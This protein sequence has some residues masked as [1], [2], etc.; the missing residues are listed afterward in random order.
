MVKQCSIVLVLACM[1][2]SCVHHRPKP[3]PIDTLP[4]KRITQNRALDSFNY[5]DVQ[6]RINV[7]LHTGYRQPRLILRGDT[8]DLAQLKVQ[9]RGQTLELILGKGFPHH[10]PIHADIHS[11]YLNGFKYDGYGSINGPNLHTSAI[12]L[13]ITNDGATRLSGVLGV[14][15]LRLAGKGFTSINGLSSNHL[16]LYLKGSPKVQ[17][18]GKANISNVVMGGNTWFSFYWLK[19]DTMVV[20]AKD[21]ARIQ[22]AG[23]VNRLDVELWGRAQFKGRYLR[24]Q[25]SFVK[26]HDRAVAEISAVNHQSNLATDASDIY[27]FNLANTRADFMAYNGSVLDMREWDRINYRDFDRY[28]KQ[29]P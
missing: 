16:Q 20:R 8:R 17:L 12:N 19:S 26:T 24:A 4:A 23:T 18:T 13:D 6:G 9:M 3:Q 7:T 2:M 25:R 15:S 14:Q 1:L 21:R 27:Y 28:N 5:V 22:F 29:F 10:G 11:H